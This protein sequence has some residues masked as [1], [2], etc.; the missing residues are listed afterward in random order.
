MGGKK[1]RVGSRR[2]LDEL[3]ETH[4]G[5]ES[6]WDG[7]SRGGVGRGRERE[8]RKMGQLDDSGDGWCI[9]RSDWRPVRMGGTGYV[10][11]G[12]FALRRAPG[13][14]R[15]GNGRALG[16]EAA[17]RAGGRKKEVD[18]AWS[19][20]S[21]NQGARG[22]SDENGRNRHRRDAGSG[23]ES[24]GTGEDRRWGE[25]WEPMRRTGR[26]RRLRWRELVTDGESICSGSVGEAEQ[27]R[28]ASES[29]QTRPSGF[30]PSPS[31]L[32]PV[33]R[34]FSQ[35]PDPPNISN[36]PT[37]VMRDPVRAR[38]FPRQLVSRATPTTCSLL[39]LYSPQSHSLNFSAPTS[40]L[41]PLSTKWPDV[42]CR[43]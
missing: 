37:P 40:L 34:R 28:L 1:W 24:Y 23:V 39:P 16:G 7:K 17:G 36:L 3:K 32:V 19:D 41:Y 12:W 18:Q 31:P 8:G 14:A 4:A 22:S 11:Q 9:S 43:T 6:I 25:R 13:R 15:R 5:E 21:G 29:E 2:E 20:V 42:V 38:S 30:S 10:L 35:P 27:L 33:P 26:R